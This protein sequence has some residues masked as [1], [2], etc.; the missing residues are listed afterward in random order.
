MESIY[1]ELGLGPPKLIAKD[2]PQYRPLPSE[3]VRKAGR[4]DVVVTRWNFTPEERERI[5]KGED[6]FLAI[7]TFGK[8]LQP[9]LPSIGSETIREYL[10]S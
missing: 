10:K 5:A 7:L 8:P 9:L 4:G 2:Q 1:P 6:F 3:I